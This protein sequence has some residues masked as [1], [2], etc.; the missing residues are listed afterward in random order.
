MQ[1][2]D[3]EEMTMRDFSPTAP[4]VEL[5]DT[6]IELLGTDA[7]CPDDILL[8]V[9]R[10]IPGISLDRILITLY[11]NSALFHRRRG[12]WYLVSLDVRQHHMSYPEPTL[13][14]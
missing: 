4:S 2:A 10:R 7:L 14:A 8:L 11:E 13:S 12:R 6:I 3:H 9:R 1:W 5:V